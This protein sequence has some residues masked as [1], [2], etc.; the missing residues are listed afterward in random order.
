MVKTKDEVYLSESDLRLISSEETFNLLVNPKTSD[1]G[2]FLEKI[3]LYPVD[4]VEI[5]R[6]K[7]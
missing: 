4:E 3:N 2:E 7:L 1:F 6:R 5:E